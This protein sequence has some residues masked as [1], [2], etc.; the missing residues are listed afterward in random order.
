M[1]V[2]NTW[3]RIPSGIPSKRELREEKLR[4]V[5]ADKDWLMAQESE[6]EARRRIAVQEARDWGREGLFGQ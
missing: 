5:N 1:N 4:Q 2:H 6:A 3:R